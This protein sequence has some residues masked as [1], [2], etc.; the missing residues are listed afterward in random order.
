[1]LGL[2]RAPVPPGASPVVTAQVVKG[3]PFVRESIVDFCVAVALAAYG[4]ASAFVVDPSVARVYSPPTPGLVIL[5]LVATLSLAVRRRWPVAVLLVA[6]G[7]SAAVD[8]LGANSDVTGI[9]SL[10]ALYTVAAWRPIGVALVAVAIPLAYDLANALREGLI[11]YLAEADLLAVA[12]AFGLGLIAQRW[13][14]ARADAL[15]RAVAAERTRAI[16]AERAAVAERLRVARDLHDVVAHALSLI[17][18][19]AGVARYCDAATTDPQAAQVALAAAE[20]AS[21][22]ALHDLRRMLLALD[23]RQDE[24]PASLRPSPGLSDLD[25]LVAAAP[26]TGTVAFDVDPAALAAPPS[27]QLTAYR[28]VQEA[29]TNARK[30]SPGAD[31]RVYVGIADGELTVRV[32]DD[33]RSMSAAATTPG[34]GLGLVGMRERVA[35]F[36]GTVDAAP[37]PGGGFRVEVRLRQAGAAA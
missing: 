16:L 9:A 17:A 8:G 25:T 13:R 3:Q 10:V 31:V 14:R 32:D 26:R 2:L 36:D 11:A 4:V 15:A 6:F 19:Q 29:L 34:T 18:V 21:R 28:L 33:G 30:H 1:M 12:V 27:M 37:V 35:L 24:G 20:E 22:T 23:S 7:S 5:I